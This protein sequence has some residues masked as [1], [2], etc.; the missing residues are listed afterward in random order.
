MGNKQLGIPQATALALAQRL[1]IKTFIETGTYR[2]GTA[3]WA[4][5]CG[6]FNRVITIEGY[7]KRYDGNIATY[8]L[9]TLPGLEF[10]YGDSRTQLPEILKTVSE[11]AMFWLDAHWIGDSKIAYVQRDECP[12]VEELLAINAHPASPSHVILIDDARLFIAPPPYPHHPEQWPNL[13][14]IEVLLKHHA[15]GIEVKEDVIW[16]VP[17]F[18]EVLLH[19]LLEEAT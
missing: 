2:A 18:H 15:R 8:G 9:N 1:K 14:E 17:Y 6:Q 4:S 7:K 10:V 16:A 3:L 11:P 5:N 13:H 19:N 12:L